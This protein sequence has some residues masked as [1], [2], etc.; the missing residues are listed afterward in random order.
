LR[1]FAKGSSPRSKKKWDV[2]LAPDSQEVGVVTAES[3]WDA[4]DGPD[5]LGHVLAD[6]AVAT[7]RGSLVDAVLVDNLDREAVELWFAEVLHVA[8]EA[9]AD[10]AVELPYVRFLA[11]LIDRAHP[12]DMFDIGELVQWLAADALGRTAVSVKIERRFK[13]LKPGEQRV[14]S[15]VTDDWVVLDVVPVVVIAERLAQLVGLLAGGLGVDILNGL[16]VS[17]RV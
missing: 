5:V 15:S 2:H 10:S 8:V 7:R 6:L 13:S 3:L 12:G 9:I 4:G 14:V 17:P 16:E 11:A 1:G